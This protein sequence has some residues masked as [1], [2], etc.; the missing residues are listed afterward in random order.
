VGTPRGVLV[1]VFAEGNQDVTG[2]TYGGSAMA[3]VTGSPV[4]Q[5]TGEVGEIH[6]FFLGSS[7]P[8]GAQTVEVTVSG[9]IDRGAVAYT[10]T[11]AGD[12]EVVDT[13]AITSGE[14]GVQSPSGTLSLGGQECFCAEAWFDG[15]S[16]PG[17]IDPLT[18]WTLA[19]EEDLGVASGG[20]YY[21][22]I[23]GTADVT[24]GYTSGAANHLAVL[25]VAIRDTG[26]GSEGV[27]PEIVQPL[28]P[29][30]R[31]D[32]RFRHLL[33]DPQLLFPA[34]P[35]PG[36]FLPV[37]P[38]LMRQTRYRRLG[39]SHN[40]DYPQTPSIDVGYVHVLPQRNVRRTGRYH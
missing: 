9:A 16:N 22:D 11:G 14:S 4:T 34:T 21:Y 10:V 39:V 7:V 15:A 35:A 31:L 25:G 20:S 2:V 33:G 3:Q 37:V 18:N 29:L 5:T 30:P 23:V 40:D 27:T 32:T 28:P 36:A 24:F 1:F 19:E 17:A 6:G 8:T 26:G 13:T 12:T 38:A